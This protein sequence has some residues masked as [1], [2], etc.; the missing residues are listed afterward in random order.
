MSN[1]VVNALRILWGRL[2]EQG[3]QATATWAIDHIV[4]IVTGAPMRSVSQITP[5]LH[6]GGQYRQRG[7]ERLAA[8]GITAVVNL[9]IEFDDE[10]A[11]IAPQR[12]LYLPTIDDTPPSLE[13]L[14]AGVDFIRKEIERGGGVYVH[15]GS[16]VGRAP[17]MA[18]T[19]LVS[20]GLTPEQAWARIR[21]RRP[22]I[23]PKAKQISQV[24][25]F[26]REL[27]REREPGQPERS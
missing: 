19:Y 1:A 26:A 20:T 27:H 23:R 16:G 4:R 10:A 3:G 9:R 17:T 2:T 13:D 21:E 11:G 14:R 6:V 12:Y 18:V 22:F 24:D 8:R 15:C 7:W 5:Q 25:R